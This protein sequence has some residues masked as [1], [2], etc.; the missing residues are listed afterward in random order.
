MIMLVRVLLSI[1]PDQIR[2]I[3]K[4]GEFYREWGRYVLT[5]YLGFQWGLFSSV[6]MGHWTGCWD[7][8]DK[9]GFSWI[10]WLH[11]HSQ[12]RQY[13][14]FHVQQYLRFILK[15]NELDRGN[16]RTTL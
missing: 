2:W 15:L 11:D 7:I 6:E 9:C 1:I 5:F 14:K 8:R 13:L 3:M 4:H 12:E 10:N 16:G